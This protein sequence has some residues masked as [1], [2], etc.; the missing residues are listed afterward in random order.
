M[1]DIE[2]DLNTTQEALRRQQPHPPGTGIHK[3]TV[4][5][6]K[7][8]PPAILQHLGVFLPA[9]RFE[10]SSSTIMWHHFKGQTL[11]DVMKEAQEGLHWP[12][13][14]TVLEAQLSVT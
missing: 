3:R 9:Q 6:T 10:T 5:A 7:P 4:P 2:H 11:G 13:R 1:L 14:V 12:P 8:K